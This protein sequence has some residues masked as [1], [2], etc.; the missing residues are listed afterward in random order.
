MQLIGS[1]YTLILGLGIAG[2][3][4]ARHLLAQGASVAIADTRESVEGL[5][6]LLADYPDVPRRFADL[7]T[8]EWVAQA[9]EIVL[10]PGLSMDDP[11]V[12][13]AVKAQVP[14]IGELDL[15]RRAAPDQKIVAITAHR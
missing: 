11:L 8:P 7:L 4:C 9:S 1:S 13:E 5:D 6:A 12:A 2:M 10:A 15:L 3:S 14:I